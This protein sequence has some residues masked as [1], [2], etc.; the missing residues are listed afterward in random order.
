MT[1]YILTA[2]LC[3]S[4]LAC[5]QSLPPHQSGQVNYPG[6]IAGVWCE[7]SHGAL[8]ADSEC[9]AVWLEPGEGYHYTWSTGREETEHGT[10]AAGRGLHFR[11]TYETFCY[12]GPNAGQP[13]HYT[14]PSP[15]F[16]NYSA[17]G[18]FGDGTLTLHFA[19]DSVTLE[20]FE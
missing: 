10:I 12:F 6:E 16:K 14:V 18:T 3:L 17:I 4:A 13:G 8:T 1:N 2:I 11:P 7:A 5:N 19:T 9:L 15:C 20:Q